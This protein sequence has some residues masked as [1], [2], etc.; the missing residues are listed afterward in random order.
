MECTPPLDR[1]PRIVIAAVQVPFVSGGAESHIESLRRE[2]VVRDYD[3]DVVRLPFKWYPP[4]QIIN[5]AL[6][7]RLID[8]THSYGLP[9]DLA[10]VTRFPSYCIRHPRKVAW[11]LHQHRQVYD[12]LNTDYTD[13]K[14]IP[15]DDEVRKLLYEMD[16]RSLKECRKVFTNSK[17]VS[18]RMK[19]Y[20][21]IDSQHLYHPPRLQVNIIQKNTVIIFL[22]PAGWK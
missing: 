12:F 15:D 17:N 7:W 8:L 18:K 6:A 20:L 22:L 11:V 3:V 5:D 10:I 19:K 16:S 2:L 14:D 13:F 9:V 21:D 1:K 4:R